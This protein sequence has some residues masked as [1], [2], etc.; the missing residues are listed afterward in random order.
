M[1][2]DEPSYPIWDVY[3]RRR[4]HMFGSKEEMLSEIDLG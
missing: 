3:I 2:I 4:I 1:I